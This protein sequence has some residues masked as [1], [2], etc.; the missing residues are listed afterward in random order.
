MNNGNR[1]FDVLDAMRADPYI[2][3]REV[4][5]QTG[6][7]LGSVQYHVQKLVAEGYVVQTV[8]KTCR[9]TPRWH[10]SRKKVSV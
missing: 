8:C 1:Q 6:M 3:M 7:A 4:G 10:V 9:R 5:R 2:S